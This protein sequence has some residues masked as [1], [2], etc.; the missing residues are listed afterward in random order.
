MGL[1]ELTKMGFDVLDQWCTEKVT[2]FHFCVPS[3]WRG[4]LAPAEP[5]RVPGG[6]L[7]R[8]LLPVHASL[9]RR[10]GA[11]SHH[12]WLQPDSDTHPAAEGDPGQRWEDPPGSP[13]ASPSSEAPKAPRHH[14]G[15]QPPPGEPA[16]AAGEESPG[17]R[18]PESMRG[19]GG[20]RP[21]LSWKIESENITPWKRWRV[22]D[23]IISRALF[24]QIIRV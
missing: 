15:P 18:S 11:T 10:H 2:Y 23:W 5:W 20:W 16:G 12:L 17:F 7:G 19:R 13:A 6:G 4:L 14:Q 1:Q 8:G 21:K 22:I 3:C 9:P 24:T